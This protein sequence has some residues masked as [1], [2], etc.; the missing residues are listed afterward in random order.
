MAAQFQAPDQIDDQLLI[1]IVVEGDIEVAT[2]SGDIDLVAAGIDEETSGA[3]L[4]VLDGN[5]RRSHPADVGGV[6]VVGVLV[7]PRRGVTLEIH[8]LDN[9]GGAVADK[10]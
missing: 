8:A 10:V 3:R 2:I 9:L 5:P 6:E 4:D 1:A 7:R